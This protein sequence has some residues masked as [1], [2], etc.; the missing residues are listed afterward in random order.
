[1]KRFR[2]FVIFGSSDMDASGFED[3]PWWFQCACAVVFPP[4]DLSRSSWYHYM[5]SWGSL[6]LQRGGTIKGEHNWTL[7]LLLLLS[8][9]SGTK[10]LGSLANHRAST[11]AVLVPLWGGSITRMDS[12]T[13]LSICMHPDLSGGLLVSA[14]LVVWWQLGR[15]LPSPLEPG[16]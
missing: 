4:E 11:S 13:Y 16:I 6:V 12:V 14:T 1:M 9:C 10:C 2:A 8:G 5:T 7:G 3:E 15:S